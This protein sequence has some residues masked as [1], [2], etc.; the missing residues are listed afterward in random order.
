METKVE[1]LK[2]SN[3]DALDPTLYAE[4][5]YGG[6]N[7]PSEADKTVFLWYQDQAYDIFKQGKLNHRSIFYRAF[8]NYSNEEGKSMTQR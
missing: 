4:I 8:V 1:K 6:S 3:A 5:F 7:Y 2:F